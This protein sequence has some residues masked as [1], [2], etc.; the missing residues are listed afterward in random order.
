L[1][2]LFNAY[3]MVDWS[4]AAAP[5]TGKDSVWIGVLKRDIRFRPTFEAFNP[6]TRQEGEKL[7]RE[8][9]VDLRRRGDKALLGFDFALGFPAGTAQMLKTKTPDWAG[10]WQFLAANVVDKADNNNNRFA[11]AAKMNRL[12]TDQPWPFWGAP[13]KDAQRW[14]STTKPTIP[15]DFPLA[16]LRLADMATQGLGKAGAKSVWQVFGNGTVGSQTLMGVPALKRLLDELGDK[17]L[18]WP[19]QTG[20]REITPGDLQDREAVAA[21]VYP[22]LIPITPEPGEIPDRAQV[23]SLCD[24]FAKLDEQGKLGALFAAPKTASPELIADVEREE[25]W[26]LG[27]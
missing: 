17:A 23:R 18:V 3:V 1:A 7:L 9:M 21:E 26:I 15:A 12:M 13:P 14:L 6:A 11:V 16:Q 4:A 8:V 19:F 2:R 24:H 22:A 20:W 27:A 10:L 5:K 25:G